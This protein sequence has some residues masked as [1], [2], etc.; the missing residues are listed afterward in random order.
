MLGQAL[1]IGWDLNQK[2]L[3]QPHRHPSTEV[4]LFCY[5]VLVWFLMIYTT[6]GNRAPGQYAW[7]TNYNFSHLFSFPTPEWSNIWRQPYW[8]PWQT[9]PPHPAIWNTLPASLHGLPTSLVSV[10]GPQMLNPGLQK[11]LQIAWIYTEQVANPRSVP[12]EGVLGLTCTHR[13]RNGYTAHR[14]NLH[15]ERQN[16]CFGA[17]AEIWK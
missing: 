12:C 11:Q 16:A 13:G 2:V 7:S 17:M 15:P 14:T 8:N 10:P 6:A 5:F 9:S 3:P 1:S 4:L